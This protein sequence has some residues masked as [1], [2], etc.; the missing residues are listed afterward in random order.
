M[1]NSEKID[2]VRRQLL[3][4]LPLAE[5]QGA[6]MLA[7]LISLAAAEADDVMAG[8]RTSELPPKPRRS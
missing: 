4:L 1:A 3:E 5:R 6:D 8:R 7:Y 2:E